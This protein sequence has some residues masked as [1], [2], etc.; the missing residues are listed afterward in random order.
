MSGTNAHAVLEEAPQAAS[1]ASIPARS[2]ELV[3]LSAKNAAALHATAARLRDHLDTSPELSLGDLAFSLATTRSPMERRGAIATTSR[4]ALRAAL[5]S[6][7]AGQPAPGAVQGR[8][9]SG[10]TPKVVFVFPGQGSQWLGMGRQLL[11]EE[12][13]FRAVLVACD[14]AIKAEAGWSLLEELG[15]DEVTSQLARIDVVQ[16]ALFA[17]EVA[18]AALWQSWGVTPDAVVGHSMGE[19]AAAHVA[20]ALSLEDAVAIICRRSRLMRRVSGQGEMAVVELTVSEAEAALQGYE[21]RL[22]VAVSNSPRSTVLSG[23][24]AALSEVLAA[25]ESRGVF[26]RRVKVDVASHSPQ[27]NPLRE[28]LLAALGGLEPRPASVPMR[29]TVLGTVVGG[30]E[31]V[32]SYWVDNLR[33]PVRFGD[34]VQALIEDGHGL[35]IEMSPHPLLVPAIKEVQATAGKDGVATGSLR[36]GGHESVAMLEALGT[37]WVH[38][39]PVPWM[40]ILRTSRRV[41]LPTYPWQRERYWLEEPTGGAIGVRHRGHEDG[42]PLLG[43]MRAL[44][45]QAGTRV[46]ETAVDLQRL[47]WLTDHRVQG[48]VVFPGAAYLE[49][50]LASGAES[51]GERAFEVSD[52]AI[53]EALALAGDTTIPVQLV[54]TEERPGLSRFQIASMLQGS[55]SSWRV[56]AR[57][58][59]RRVDPSESTRPPEVAT[60][61]ARLGSSEASDTTYAGLAGLGLEYG[62]AFRGLRELWRGDGEALGLIRLPGAAGGSAAYQWHP[63]L[64]DACFHVMAATFGDTDEP[65]PWVPVAVASLRL[66]RRLGGDLWCHVTWTKSDGHSADRRRADLQVVD[67]SGMIVAEVA[68]LVLQRVAVTAPRR[69]DDDWFLALDWEAVA[70]PE[71]RVSGGRWLLLGDRGNVGPALRMALEAKGHAAVHAS[72]LDTTVASLRSVLGQSFSGE[73]PTAIVHLASLDESQGSEADALEPALRSCDSVL[74]TVQAVAAMGWRDTPRLWL[75]TRGAQPAGG[76]D[77]AV[78]GTP[79][80]GLARVAALEH[81]ELRCGRVDLDRGRPADEIDQLLAE[82]LADGDEDEVAL[83]AGGRYVARLAHRLPDASRREI[84]TA[85][86]RPFRLEIDQPGVLDRLVL[87]AVEPRLPQ[88]GEVQIAVEAAG[89]NFI[90]VM[91]AMGVYPGLADGPVALGGECAGRIVAVGKGVTDFAVGQDI[92]AIAPF[93]FGTHVTV[94]ARMVASRPAGLSAAEAAGLPIVLMTAWYGLVSLGRLERGERVLIHSATGGTGLAAVQIAQ[95]LGAEIYATAGTAEKRAWLR[96]QGIAHAMDSRSLDFAEQVLAATGGQGV[97]VVLNSLSGAAIEASLATLGPD[98]RFIELGKTDIYADHQLGLAHF[99]KSLSYSAVDLAGLAERRP[100]RFGALLAEVMDLV[101]RGILRPLPVETFPI[102]QATVAF[103]KM[104]QAQHRGKII[105][106]PDGADAQIRVPADSRFT[107]RQDGSYLLTGGLGGL[108]LRLAEWLAQRG[109]G[110]L[111]LVG[112]S[113]AATPE[114]QAAVAALRARGTAVTVVRADVTDRGQMQRV[115]DEIAQQARPLRGIVHAAGLLDDGLLLNQDPPRFRNVMAPK[116]QGAWHLHT[117]TRT[118]SLDFFVMFASA[119]GLIGSPGQANY[120]AANAF[121]DALAYHRR[122]HGLPGLSVDWAAFS[123]V[124]LAAAQD[125]RGARLTS[126]GMRN[127]TPDEGLSVLERLLEAGEVHIGV[128]PLDVRQWVEFYPAAA[129]SRMLSRLL[130]ERQGGSPR[131]A[132]DEELLERLAT[133]EPDARTAILQAALCALVSQ[134]L[135][136]PEDRLDTEIPLTDLGMDSLMGLE[137]RNRIEGALGITMPATLLWTYPTGAALAR[138]L[139]ASFGGNGAASTHAVKRPETPPA[140]MAEP[141][142]ELSDDELLEALRSE[143]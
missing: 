84:E 9:S 10:R 114:Q 37:L 82:L 124:G 111:V 56:H 96:E 8:V 73:A 43:H 119:A 83:R 58:S 53:S 21:D 50:A 69:E 121:L 105:L 40:R 49:M 47:P 67:G 74:A 129:S 101:S 32:A 133:A 7:A 94:D 92:V 19:V 75:V 61:R 132:G 115:L 135:R 141:S 112:R 44:S 26:Y 29:S 100:E 90:D 14:R 107:V 22:S 137:L 128:V 143:I 99:K 3:V 70:V 108:G 139:S 113:G 12:P 38:G 120:A 125:N 142:P 116:V 78:A 31:L 18:L 126:R 45:T 95:H 140:A 71:T 97:D 68:G 24:T 102:T 6:M 86:D 57:G 42:H 36:R 17:M 5:E 106:V 118:A 34:A 2:A 89:L 16:P 23:E 136:L 85:A 33:Q 15:A 48:T 35:F 65:A 93:S 110:H 51:F 131:P 81:A 54:T 46:W 103:R 98:G 91:K 41:V 117:L 76:G 109:A 60:L 62:P 11:A 28:D 25:L 39:Y 122:A 123:E 104:A 127:L 88:P 66:F 30:E 130:S 77:V 20:G 63:A 27:V 4:E 59:L 64:L 72:P 13:V 79:I 52:V 138:H 55:R 87:R 1:G 80:L 134:V